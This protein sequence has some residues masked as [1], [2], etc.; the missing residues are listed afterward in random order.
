MFGLPLL[1]G[2]SIVIREFV[3]TCAAYLTLPATDADRGVI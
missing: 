2:D 1:G 3:L